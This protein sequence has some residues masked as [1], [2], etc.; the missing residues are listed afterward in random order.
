KRL[1]RDLA[2]AVQDFHEARH[3]RALEVVRQ[4]HVHVETGYRVLLARGSILDSHRVADVL[5][6]HAV[7]GQF[8]RV[9]ARL[10]VLDLGDGSAREL[11]GGERRSHDA[12]A[13]RKR[14]DSCIVSGAA[15]PRNTSY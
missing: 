9:E 15:V 3:M 13:Y 4:A 7:D 11:G 8:A 6:A 10:H 2:L 14:P 5:D 1:H 12:K